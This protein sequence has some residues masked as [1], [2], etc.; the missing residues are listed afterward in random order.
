[1]SKTQK[2]LITRFGGIGDIVLLT[3]TL[4]A[5]TERDGVAPDLVAGAGWVFPTL[6]NCPY[7][8]DI[9]LLGKRGLPR[10]FNASSRK[11]KKDLKNKIYK[12]IYNLHEE[13]RTA[14]HF[15]FLDLSPLASY[16]GNSIEHESSRRLRET[17]LRA[18][19]LLEKALPQIF[20]TQSDIDSLLN[21]DPVY[22]EGFILVQPG[23]KKTMGRGDSTRSSNTKFWS[24][25]KWR[26]VISSLVSAHPNTAILVIGS[27][28]ESDYI[29][30]IISP[31]KSSRIR[32]YSSDLNLL[33]LKAACTLAAGMITVDTGPAH[34][35]AALGCPMIELFGPC[36]PESHAPL[37]LGQ[38]IEML[39]KFNN[40]SE[41]ANYL[42]SIGLITPAEVI[43]KFESAFDFHRTAPLSRIS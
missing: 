32:N 33:E 38:K 10:F 11:L 40:E 41:K 18:E 37:N 13:P 7:V 17:G 21:K 1:M 2:S 28:S 14:R 5:L 24:N 8:S 15:D 16:Q 19:S 4:K 25:E 9:Y 27:P 23:N 36:T 34:I 6:K 43:E 3:P 39:V 20:T 42:S 29:D 30:E 22:K 26:E 31:I 12:N 35:A